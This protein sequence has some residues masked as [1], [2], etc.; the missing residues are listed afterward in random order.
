MYANVSG[1]LAHKNSLNV[2]GYCTPK[3]GHKPFGV[4]YNFRQ[5]LFAYSC[6]INAV[7][8]DADGAGEGRFIATLS[9]RPGGAGPHKLSE[10]LAQRLY[11]LSAQHR[12]A[13][14]CRDPYLHPGITQ[15]YSVGRRRPDS[16]PDRIRSRLQKALCQT[17]L[18][19]L[20][21]NVSRI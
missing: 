14:V 12:D 16:G 11:N 18:Y 10:P 7:H 6:A 21:A 13:G 1:A 20:N 15:K 5:S 9:Y 8:G 3:V 2:T 4:Q 19:N 17:W